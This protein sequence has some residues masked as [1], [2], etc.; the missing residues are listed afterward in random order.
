M[1]TK[2]AA[3][4]TRAAAG[5]DRVRYDDFAMAL[6]WTTA[7]LVL[8]LFMLAKFWR[9]VPRPFRHEM[10][11]AHMSFGILLTLVLVVRIGWRLPPGHRV[12]PA[13]TG[14]E[15]IV[16]TAA[17]RLL[18]GLLAAQALLGFVLRW[19]GNEAMSFFGLLIPPPFAKFSKPAHHFVGQLHNWGAW[20]IIILAAGHAGAALVHHYIL[21]DDVLRRMLPGINP[22]RAEQ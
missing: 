6:H 16:S 8:L 21:R 22:R 2:L 12:R 1:T 14:V 9:A 18:Y 10:I 19:S 3:A 20:T 5:D 7:V 17:H 4:A 15:A 13:V 11:V